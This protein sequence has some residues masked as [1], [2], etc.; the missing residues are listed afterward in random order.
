VM[1]SIDL[2]LTPMMK[3][4]YDKAYDKADILPF[5]R[6]IWDA[7]TSASLKRA[8]EP[9]APPPVT[10][11]TVLDQMLNCV[12]STDALSLSVMVAFDTVLSY[13]AKNPD[14]AF[15]NRSPAE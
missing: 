6:S 4:L 2:L 10:T 5:P 13:M 3:R 1:V 15:T 8:L 9:H 14:A 11:A 12:K 7:M